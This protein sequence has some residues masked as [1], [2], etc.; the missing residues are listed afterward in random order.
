VARLGALPAW[1]REAARPGASPAVERS[2]SG[3]GPRRRRQAAKVGPRRRRRL[4]RGEGSDARETGRSIDSLQYGGEGLG[5][6]EG[7]AAIGGIPLGIVVD[8]Q[9]QFLGY[10]NNRYSVDP[11]PIPNSRVQY[12]HPNGV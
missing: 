1:R 9:F 3:A 5:I 10:P 2:W 6:E 8:F 4:H 12:L 7:V 11:I